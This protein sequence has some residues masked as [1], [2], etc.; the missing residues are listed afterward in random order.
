MNPP[1]T[2]I[3]GGCAPQPLAAYLKALAVLRLVASQADAEARGVWQ[4]ESFALISRLDRAG[5]ERFLLHDWRPT[6]IAAPWNGGS[7]FW[8]KDNKTAVQALRAATAGRLAPLAETLA[9]AERESARLGLSEAPKDEAKH[10]F[11]AR[12]RARLSDAALDWLDAAVLL[13]EDKP[14]YPPLLGT[15]G[16][17]GRLDFTNNYHQRLLDLF[18]PASG[19]PTAAAPGWLAG[20]LFGETVPGLLR[21]AVGQFAPGSA[22]GPNATCGLEADSLVNPWDFVLT[23]EGAL[24]FAAAA[25]RRLDGSGSAALAYPFTVLSTG[26]GSG[27]TATAD[28]GSSRAEM[29]LPLWDQP[30]SWPDLRAVLAEGRATVGRRAARDGLDFARAAASL[31]LA[32]GITGFQRVGFLMRSGKAYL[33]TPLGRVRVARRIEADLIGQLEHNDWLGR[34]SAAARQDKAP[35]RLVSLHGRLM[36]ALFQMADRGGDRPVREAL[37][38]LGAVLLLA[39]RSRALREVLPPPPRLEQNWV[40]RADDGTAAFR[41]AC[42]L[43]SLNGGLPMIRHMVATNETDQ[44]LVTWGPGSLCGNLSRLLRRRL[45]EEG[46]KVSPL[47][48]GDP[49]DSAAVAAFLADD[50]QDAGIAALLPGL[51]LVRSWPTR[52]AGRPG[53]SALPLAYALM[54]PLFTPLDVL[55]RDGLLGEDQ[56]LPLPPALPALLAAGRT[57]EALATARRRL[58]ASGL[59]SPFLA[60]PVAAGMSGE[61]LLAALLVPLDRA[62]RRHLSRS[63]GLVPD[64]DQPSKYGA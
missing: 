56:T 47:T 18:D 37:I 35:A 17:D 55:R 23:I 48:A 45:L 20:A 41:V 32:R 13:T 27:A 33:A 19:A 10:A 42:A 46:E 58:R 1:Y 15:G 25:T 59:A 26:A 43:A 31:G 49:A 12:L 5:L 61:R 50:G 9:L 38:C 57:D 29:W 16:N 24:A 54:K 7:G 64:A 34:L 3:L 39:A 21:A 51:A 36:E 63:A 11:V 44:H 6:P 40:D 22:G 53:D 14:R 60:A 28:E 8:P 4:G 52:S 62:S 30:A 2:V